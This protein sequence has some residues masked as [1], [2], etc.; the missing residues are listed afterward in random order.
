M[1]LDFT[2]TKGGA[3]VYC[4]DASEYDENLPA[5]Q[6]AEAVQAVQEKLAIAQ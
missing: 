5:P 2:L 4:E 1:F 3:F 6:N